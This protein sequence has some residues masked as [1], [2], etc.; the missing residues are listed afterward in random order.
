MKSVTSTMHTTVEQERLFASQYQMALQAQISEAQ[1]R[2]KVS[3]H[4]Q[5]HCIGTSNTLLCCG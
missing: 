4:T 5:S 3:T 1:A 2:V